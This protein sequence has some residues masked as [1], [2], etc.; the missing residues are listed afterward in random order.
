MATAQDRPESA[1][2]GQNWPK[3]AETGRKIL[4]MFGGQA[5]GLAL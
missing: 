2:I 1:K 5:Q 3:L 4:E